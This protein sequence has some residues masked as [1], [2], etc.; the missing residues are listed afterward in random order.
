[1]DKILKVGL[2]DDEQ[3]TLDDIRE[4]LMYYSGFKLVFA[5]TDPLEGLARADQ[6]EADILILDVMIPRLSGLEISERLGNSGIP[7]I[8]CSA[9]DTFAV[10]GYQQNAVYFLSKPVE[11]K[12]LY[13]GLGKAAD[14][15]NRKWEKKIARSANFK[16]INSNGGVTGEVLVLPKIDYLEQSGNYTTIYMGKTNKVIVSSLIRTL[17]GIDSDDFLQVHKSYAVNITK[18][19]KIQYAELILNRGKKI[20]IG[21]LYRRKVDQ[22]LGPNML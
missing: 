2:I 12:E 21:R 17:Q 10:K 13:I 8:L 11:Q 3:A 20:P 5:T 16:I 14:L 7:I 1:M 4:M 15:L 19:K 6:K 22:R 18:I 9:N